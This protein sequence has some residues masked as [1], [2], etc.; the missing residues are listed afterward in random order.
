ML[1]SRVRLLATPWIVAYQAPPSM[2]FSRQ[3]YWS[4]VPLPSLDSG[5]MLTST[6]PACPAAAGLTPAAA[7]W[8]FRPVQGTALSP[9]AQHRWGRERRPYPWSLGP[10]PKVSSEL[11]LWGQQRVGTRVELWPRSLMQAS[12]GRVVV[13]VKV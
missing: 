5:R 3:E 6:Q 8:S 4:G 9:R 10:L 12:I 1:L 7:C 2:G 11:K 13:G